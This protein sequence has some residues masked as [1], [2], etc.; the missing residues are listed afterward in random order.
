MILMNINGCLVHRT[1]EMIKFKKPKGQ[2][3]DPKFD[4]WVKTFKVK[5]N[6]IYLRD[7]YMEFLRLL[8]NHP[9]VSFSFCSA[10]MRKN[11]LPI[12][13]EMFNGNDD[14]LGLL[15]EQL[16]NIFDQDYNRSAPEITGE[17]YGFIRDLDKV[18]ACKRLPKGTTKANILSLE[19]DEV[20]VHDCYE[21]SLVIDT[22]ERDDIW[23]DPA[24]PE[25]YRDQIKILKSIKNDLFKMLDQCQSD[26]P[27]FLK[28]TKNHSEDAGEND[29][30]QWGEHLRKAKQVSKGTPAD[31]QELTSAMDK[32]NV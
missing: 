19:S 7:G 18:L 4:R 23:P 22:Y 29:G 15:Q 24:A 10:I 12:I 9:R 13:L 11:I 30:F 32:L 21:N 27:E 2:E 14:D 26:V 8:M 25:K 17:K 5:K 6:Y 3:K 20:S 1:S 28:S 16:F 31:T